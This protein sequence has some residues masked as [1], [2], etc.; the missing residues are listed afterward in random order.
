MLLE[1]P[2]L[3]IGL[4]NALGLPALQLGLARLFH[5]LPVAWFE[6]NP[7]STGRLSASR[8]SRLLRRWKRWL[9]DG[10]AWF[11]GGFPKARL[12]SRDPAYLRR[13]LAETRRGEVCHWCFLA[14]TPLFFLW[15]PPWACGVIVLYA[16]AANLP[17]IAV[18]RFNRRRLAITLARSPAHSSAPARS[19]HL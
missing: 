3:A 1:L 12:R 4:L 18:Q 2:P 15:N 16:L 14:L 13:F 10:A 8:R 6:G 17:C 5:E 7:A 11:A 19:E 9:P